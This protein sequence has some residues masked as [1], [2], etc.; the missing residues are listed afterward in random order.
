VTLLKKAIPGEFRLAFDAAGRR[1][2]TLRGPDGQP[3]AGV[4]L[5]PLTVRPRQPGYGPVTLPDALVDRMEATTGPDG[6]VELAC[7]E[8]TTELY[9]VRATIPG[10]GTN[11]LSLPDD[12]VKSE[13]VVLDLKPVGRMAGRVLRYDGKP[14]SG[15]EVDIW[16][17][18]GSSGSLQPV[19][20]EAGPV[21]T[22]EDGTFR[23][24]PAL[25]A[26]VKYRALIRAEGFKP[27]L[28]E[29]V[30]PEGRA[31]A[32]V[33]L[34]EVVLISPL[35]VVGRVVDRQGRPVAGAEIVAGGESASAVTDEQGRFRLAGL[36]PSQT[37]LI[38]RRDG[39][40]IDGRML[41]KGERD[42]EVVLARFD[43][44]AARPM[45]TLGSPIPLEERRRLARRVLEPFLVKVLARGEDSTKAWA[46]RSLMV[47]DPAATLEAL[48]QTTFRNMEHYYQSF[49][50]RELARTMAREDPE[51]AAAVAESI[52]D[53]FR[54]AEALVDVCVEM[55]DDQRTRKRQLIDQVLLSARA[56]PVPKWRVWQLGEAAELLLDVGETDR[57]KAVFA[58]GRPIAERL[59]PDAIGIVGYFASRLGRVDLPAALALLGEVEQ[60][61]SHIVA[62]GNL[63]ARIA[64]INPAEAERLVRKIR[65]LRGSFGVTL[66]TCQNMA[67]TD[68]P[69]ARRIAMDQESAGGLRASALIFT[70]CGLPPSQR[71]A[72]RDIV[73]QA[74]PELDRAR[75]EFHLYRTYVAACMPVVESID[76]ALVPELFWRTVAD[77]AIADDPRESYGRDDVLGQ[78][79]LLARYDREVAS[80]LFE[81]AARASAARGADAGQMVPNELLLLAVIDP[82][83]AVAAV[84]AMPEPANLDTRGVNWSRI[85]LSDHLGR[86][87]EKL[88]SHIWAIF[89]GLGGVLGRRDVL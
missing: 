77:L 72:A 15:A 20:F 76:P 49:L 86:D 19:R 14:A 51:E 78:A 43:E 1:T 70:A 57:A 79:L 64:A 18:S 30:A 42:V 32:A 88:W 33:R 24:P 23:T 46:L 59:G 29:W 35:S 65:G 48:E 41:D 40:R 69:R 9:V 74:L 34:A 22:C 89:S 81:P 36:A 50:R 17:R 21:R 80:A 38:V 7:L 5:A 3:L 66:R 2:F 28:T 11:A 67:R 37:F 47:F 82:R 61:E 83:R 45:T 16:S 84:E 75:D 85:I 54:R 6:R 68:L 60:D 26:G 10:L 39:F 12:R 31:D 58:E 55:P 53:A 73:R 4:R 62:A 56:E 52:P 87:D 25:L 27:V 8:A 13:A 63:A 44:P 71:Q